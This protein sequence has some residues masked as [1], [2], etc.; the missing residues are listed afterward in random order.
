MIGRY[1]GGCRKSITNFNLIWKL[2]IPSTNNFVCVADIYNS[3][4]K[5]VKKNTTKYKQ[6]TY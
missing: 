6:K 1:L 3:N 5:S 4:T 2:V